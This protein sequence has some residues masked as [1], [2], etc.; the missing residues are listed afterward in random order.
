MLSVI[1][2]GWDLPKLGL[3]VKTITERATLKEHLFEN[4]QEAVR[5]DVERAL[6]VLVTRLC[7]LALP[8]R[9]WYKKDISD[10]MKVC[11]IPHNMVVEA[12]RD[13]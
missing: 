13:N 12:Q 10:M 1:P 5:K 11:V 7:I 2:C 6:G 4:P 9:F 3:F 8:S